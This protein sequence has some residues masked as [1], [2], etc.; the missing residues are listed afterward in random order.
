MIKMQ[1][2]YST[3]AIPAHASFNRPD[4][5][6]LPKPEATKKIAAANGEL[7]KKF[8]DGLITEEQYNRDAIAL[9]DWLDFVQKRP[10]T[11][12]AKK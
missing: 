10:E 8:A 5:M 12:A 1:D 3:K 11:P 6:N 9:M 4:M 2:S 7:S